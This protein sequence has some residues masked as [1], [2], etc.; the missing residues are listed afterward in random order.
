MSGRTCV[1]KQQAKK[2]VIPIS[3][4]ALIHLPLSLSFFFFFFLFASLAFFS[5][6]RR[7]SRSELCTARDPIDSCRRQGMAP[8]LSLL[9]SVDGSRTARTLTRSAPSLSLSS[10]NSFA[11]DLICQIDYFLICIAGY[12]CHEIL[13]RLSWA[14]ASPACFTSESWKQG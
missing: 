5:C 9:L 1:G 13:T 12:D 14:A 11:L 4:R 10:R 7:M 3:D 6:M 8:H 2:S